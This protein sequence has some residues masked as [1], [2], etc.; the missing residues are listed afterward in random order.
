MDQTTPKPLDK[1]TRMAGIDVITSIVVM[2]VSIAVAVISLQMPRPVGWK[3]APGLMPL[4]FSI[5]LF[6]MGLGLL[7]SALRRKG[8]S[9]FMQMLSGLSMGVF[10]G[11]VRTKRTLWIILL[12]GTYIIL[13]S[14]RMPFEVAASIFLL[15]TLSV[16]WKKGG[17]TKIILISVIIPLFFGF[18]IRVLFSN[19]LPGDSIFELLL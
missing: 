7:I 5:T 10:I 18:V 8:F 6:I 1:T 4:L 19:L 17:K 3:S 2:A 9:I 14:G 15:S 11:D 12:T 16:F 13:L